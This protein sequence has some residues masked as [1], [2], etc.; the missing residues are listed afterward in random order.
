MRGLGVLNIRTIFGETAV[1]PRKKLRL[2]VH[3]EQARRRRTRPDASA[4]R[5]P[6][7]PRRS[8]AS[9]VRKVTI[10]VAAGRNLA[11]LVE[12]AVRNRRSSSCAA[13]TSTRGIHR[14]AG[15]ADADDG[16]SNAAT[17]TTACSSVLV[18]GLSGSGKSVALN[19]LEDGGYYC[20][21]NLPAKLLP[22]AWSTSCRGAATRASRSASTR[23]AATR[24]PRCREQIG[25]SASARRRRARAVS[26]G[27]DRHAAA[28]LFRDAAAPSARRRRAR[29]SPNAIEHERELLADIGGCSAPH[30]HERPQPRVLR[31][32]IRDLVGIGSGTLTLLFESFAYKHGIPLDADW[33]S[34][35]AACPIRTTIRSCAR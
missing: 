19:A 28:A 18:S 15:A 5:S 33:C 4:C 23:A 29:R 3:L 11:V 20:V 17:L 22:R 32:W 2:I 13:S 30:R 27:E 24:S 34:T 26:R 7:C 16:D 35:C 9:R 31:N 6:G 12:A 8:S 1:R 10:P 14:A 25:R 21:D